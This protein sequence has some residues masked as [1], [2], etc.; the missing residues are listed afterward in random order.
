MMVDN[1]EVIKILVQLFNPLFQKDVE[2]NNNIVWFLILRFKI[3]QVSNV[4]ES[5]VARVQSHSLHVNVKRRNDFVVIQI[6]LF[7]VFHLYNCLTLLGHNLILVLNKKLKQFS[8][9]VWRYVQ[10]LGNQS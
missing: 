4:L 8:Q 7:F 9:L 5:M 2:E 10:F 3:V 6:E 1:Y